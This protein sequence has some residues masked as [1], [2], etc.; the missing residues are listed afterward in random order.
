VQQF[1]YVAVSIQQTTDR[2][3]IVAS[4]MRDPTERQDM[5]VLKLDEGGNVVWQK[6]YGLGDTD[7]YAMSIQQTTDGGYIVAGSFDVPTSGG[8][9]WVLKLD[10]S[11]NVVWQKAYGGQNTERASSIRQTADGGYIVAGDTKTF[12]SYSDNAWLLKLDSSGNLSWEKSYGTVAA[13]NSAAF[14][15]QT[16][17][18]GYIVAGN[19]R[20]YDY[21][22]S[23]NAWILKLN[24]SGEIPG[25]NITITYPSHA[26]IT[27]PSLS[28]ID[29]DVIAQPTNAAVISTGVSPESVSS[30]G[31]NPCE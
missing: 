13:D 21:N 22:A 6:A 17:D 31:F 1:S 14:V 8:N 12:D 24:S 5:L 27:E 4:Y 30:M 29:T 19:T 2:G 7:E 16:S 15:Q 18:G 3:Y 26:I 28:V 11:G 23:D 25:C 9:A 10:E 20:T